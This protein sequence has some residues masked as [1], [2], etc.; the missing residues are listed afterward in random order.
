MTEAFDATNLSRRDRALSLG[1]VYA[2]I[3]ANGVGMGLSLPLLS[4]IM[5]RNGVS[6]TMNGI[7]AAFGALAMLAFTPFIPTL[8]ARIGTVRFLIGCYVVAAVSLLGFR[9][10]NDLALWFVLRFTL[11]CA[12]QGLFLVSELWINQIA[13]DAVRGRL[14]GIYASLVS[15]G[16]ALG[17]IIIQFL[18]T[19]GWEPFIAGSAMIMTAMI[20]LIIARRLIPPVE[21]AGARAMFGFVLRSPSAAAAGLAYGAIE[22]CLGSFLIIYAVRLGAADVSATLLI[23]AWGLGNMTLQPLIGWLADKVDRRH[24]MLLCGAV[25]LAGAVLLPVTQ[26]AGWPALILAFVWGGFIAGLYS[27]GLAHLGSNFKGSDLAAANAAFSILYAIG[28]LVGPGLGGVAIDLWN[29]HG[30]AA[31]VGLISAAFLVVVAY[32]TATFPRPQA[33]GS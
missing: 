29:P 18:G 24:V 33:G 14:V 31:V 1:A 13:T 4:L 10:T 26:G 5:E 17:P 2:C 28:T 21:H 27:V 12:L 9:A 19:T 8:A 23:T 3:F 22:I 7:N 25:A 32:R 6:G 16:F 30:L 20:P 15:A 11:N